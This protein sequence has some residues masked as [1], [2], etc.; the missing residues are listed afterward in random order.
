MS[1]VRI[2]II[3][4][5]S[6]NECDGVRLSWIWNREQNRERTGS[7][8]GSRKLERWTPTEQDSS[9]IPLP[10][11]RP[12]RLLSPERVL[13]TEATAIGHFRDPN[14]VR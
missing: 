12:E 10:S 9:S 2:E 4:N 5:S 7:E 6:W 13:W 3:S 11:P 8:T 1:D 14:L